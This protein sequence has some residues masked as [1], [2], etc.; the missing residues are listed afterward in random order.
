MFPLLLAWE[1]RASLV[2]K[3]VGLEAGK[4]KPTTA[5]MRF[6]F[7]QTAWLIKAA[8][9]VEVS[10]VQLPVLEPTSP[11]SQ[12]IFSNESV[13]FSVATRPGRIR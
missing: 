6:F 12:S 9:E 11:S 3:Q 8:L 4:S 7:D 5:R 2:A 13:S 10:D 1:L